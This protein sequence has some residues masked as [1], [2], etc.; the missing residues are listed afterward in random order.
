M[1]GSPFTEAQN[2]CATYIEPCKNVST[3]L[4][5]DQSGA[6]RQ[7]HSEFNLTSEQGD[8]ITQFTLLD[9]ASDVLNVEN[10]S[11]NCPIQESVRVRRRGRKLNFTL[12]VR[13]EKQ[14][15]F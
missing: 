3:Y 10:R 1:N 2:M 7:N 15:P 12:V 14:Y 6:W 5:S 8:N 13:G 9:V 11:K 4:K